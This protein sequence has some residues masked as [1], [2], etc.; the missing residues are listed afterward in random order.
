M[1]LSSPQRTISDI[2]PVRSAAEVEAGEGT[3]VASDQAA[4]AGD[5]LV[6]EE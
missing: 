4:E 2:P 1:W 3:E 5:A 6:D